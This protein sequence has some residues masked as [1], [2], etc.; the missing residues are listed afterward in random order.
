M[1][2]RRGKA[3]FDTADI[4]ALFF[5][6]DPSVQAG[7]TEIL[8]T[9]GGAPS[10]GSVQRIDP[11]EAEAALLH[12]GSTSSS[13]KFLAIVYELGT[14]PV[15]LDVTYDLFDALDDIPCPAPTWPRPSPS[16]CPCTKP[17]TA[18]S[19]LADEADL[20]VA[21][22]VYRA[23]DRLFS[24]IRFGIVDT[25]FR[26]E[27]EGTQTGDVIAYTWGLEQTRTTIGADYKAKST[28]MAPW[29]SIW[30]PSQPTHSTSRP[31]PSRSRQ[32][33]ADLGFV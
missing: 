13:S 10:D 3:Q 15:D 20:E 27:V 32:R 16:T 19:T 11:S 7:K 8:F 26:A 2:G 24:P 17:R 14:Q 31:P 28:L 30:A 29:S 4:L 25:G 22:S 6:G 21:P 9:V 33:L 12:R 1:Q 5:A 18:R 23:R